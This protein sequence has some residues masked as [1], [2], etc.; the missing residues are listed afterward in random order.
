[1]NYLID[2]K[3]L[4]N[5]EKKTIS[6]NERPEIVISLTT[7]ASR[8]L[9]QLVLNPDD[10]L[11]RPYLLKTVWEDHCYSSSDAS[12]NNN[13][14]LLRKN[15]SAVSGAEIELKTIPKIGFQLNA[16][17]E[18]LDIS[19]ELNTV[20]IYM[21]DNDIEAF[22]SK[23]RNRN[24]TQFIIF[25]II[26][27]VIVA[28]MIFV[29]QKQSDFKFAKKE[30]IS[31]ELLGK[32]D[33]YSLAKTGTNFNVV[34]DK[35]PFLKDKCEEKTASIYY[36]FSDLTKDRTKNLFVAICYHSNYSGYH[37]CENIKSYSLQ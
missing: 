8:L 14:S 32:C 4:F 29:L 9:T 30:T 7:T 13:I 6:S 17:I 28:S 33:T 20:E 25:T 16:T 36:D 1:M 26:T 3:I 24:D 23:D 15:L 19:N 11:S 37:Q 22:P 2:N 34:L 5:P 27:A 35:Y 12:L 31:A 21:D 10:V 18:I